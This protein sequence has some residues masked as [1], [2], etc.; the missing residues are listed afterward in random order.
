MDER[1]AGT[2][3]RLSELLGENAL[4]E[5]MAA[6]R[7][8]TGGLLDD[9]A[10]LALLA[11]EHGLAATPF[12]PLARL[13]PSR[14]VF[15]EC[16]VTGIEPHRE[17]RGRDRTGRLRRLRVSD[18]SGSMVLTLWDE[19]T[20]LVEQL[21]LV[22]GTRIRVL[23]ATLRDTRYGREIHVGRSGYIMN[24]GPP[25]EE[26][27]STPRDV[28]QL[29]EAKGRADVHGVVLRLETSG[30]GRQK[31]TTLRLFDG[32]GEVDVIVPHGQLQPPEGLAPGAEVVILNARIERSR[33]PA[34]LVCDARS[35]LKNA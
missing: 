22:P 6:L 1:D 13:D 2:R 15:C 33:G 25:P 5:R 17:F 14:P 10:L 20:S 34:V 27:P 9:G 8:E 16:T 29:G 12:T 18:D 24:E 19:E 28:G 7:R 26:G 3:T 11:D 4:R 32:T 31:T 21:G 35:G 30:R 23:A